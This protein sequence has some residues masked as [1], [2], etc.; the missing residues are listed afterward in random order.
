MKRVLKYLSIILAIF[1][2]LFI[3][4]NIIGSKKQ[5]Q[6]IST[7][8]LEANNTTTTNKSGVK[9]LPLNADILFVSNQDTGSR[10][11]EIYSMNKNGKNVNRLT[12]SDKH[13]FI[14]AIDKTKRYILT[15][16]AEKDTDSPSGLGDEDRRSLDLIN[17]QEKTETKLTPSEN[18]AE[19]RSFSSDG[20]WIVFLMKIKGEEQADIYKIKIDGTSLTKL[21]GTKTISEGDPSFSHDGNQIVFT[22]L[23]N[24]RFILKLMDSDGKNVKTIYDGGEGVT[25]GPFPPGNYDPAFSPDDKWIVFERA[26]SSNSENWGN[27]VW[28]ILKVKKD[29]TS[30]VDLSQ[31]GGHTDRAEFLPSYSPDGKS[32]IFSA[33]YNAPNSQD[34]L[35]NIL[36]MDAESGA[37][38]GKL[39]NG[40]YAVWID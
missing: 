20:Q 11:T 19:G 13:H 27:G 8:N 4:G 16:V 34:S 29:G 15:S 12:F 25:V 26:K 30:V 35:N 24:G 5:P 17:L 3:V 40:K 36:I 14:M 37:I 9:S 38:T 10:R 22:S 23:E 31:I 7:K 33:Y 6:S 1:L 28:H 21:T 32:I 39:V 18:H 2:L